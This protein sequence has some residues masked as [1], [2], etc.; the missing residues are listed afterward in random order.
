MHQSQNS[1]IEKLHSNLVVESLVIPTTLL[2]VSIFAGC[3][4]AAD[5]VLKLRN[6]IQTSVAVLLCQLNT[7]SIL[8]QQQF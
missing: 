1:E 5:F 7:F 6:S 3:T 2:L 4:A 8:Y